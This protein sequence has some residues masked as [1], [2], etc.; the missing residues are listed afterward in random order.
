MAI[1]ELSGTFLKLNFGFNATKAQSGKNPIKNE[2]NF[3]KTLTLGTANLPTSAGGADECV[4]QVRYISSGG[5]DTIDMSA[6]LENVVRDTGI[7]LVRVKAIL[8]HL[9]GST[10]YQGPSGSEITGSACTAIRVGNATGHTWKGF[11][12]T[13]AS[14]VDALN[15]GFV[16]VGTR[17][18]QGYH[19]SSGMNDQLKVENL[20]GSVTAAYVF[21]LLGGAS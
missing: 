19:L 5:T 21:G 15:A 3:V 17:G 14:M 12:A 11:F 20:D 10:E 18:P 2:E 8:F 1:T 6:A 9:L 4:F 16:A 7:T 13:T